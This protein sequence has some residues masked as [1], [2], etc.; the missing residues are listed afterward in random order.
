MLTELDIAR[1]LLGAQR[2]HELA[3]LERVEER[4]G[5]GSMFGQQ[6][7]LAFPVQMGS[8]RFQSEVRRGSCA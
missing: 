5:G 8:L 6:H 4:S 7:L 3:A 1:S 2:Q